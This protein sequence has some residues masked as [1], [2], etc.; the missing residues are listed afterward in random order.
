MKVQQISRIRSQWSQSPIKMPQ[1]ILSV[2]CYSG[3]YC[4]V[5]ERHTSTFKGT[6]HFF[7]LRLFSVSYKS[8]A[9]LW[10]MESHCYRPDLFSV[11][12]QHNESSRGWNKGHNFYKVVIFPSRCTG[13]LGQKQI[14]LEILLLRLCYAAWRVS[15]KSQEISKKSFMCGFTSLDIILA[16]NCHVF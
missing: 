15:M 6:K 7:P 12:G 16:V 5:I 4:S 8:P 13:A 9:L 1:T 14:H 10:V 3:S 11:M 2:S